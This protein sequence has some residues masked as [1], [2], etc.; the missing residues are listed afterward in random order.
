MKLISPQRP[1]SYLWVIVIEVIIA[2]LLM[3]GGVFIDL[4]IYNPPP[5][6][7]GFPFP[8][9]TILFMALS[10]LVIGISVIVVTIRIFYLYRKQKKTETKNETEN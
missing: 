1:F 7:V 4:A 10:G 2:I 9:V 5:G 6:T 8:M 3:I